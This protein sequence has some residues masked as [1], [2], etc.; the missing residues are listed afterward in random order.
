MYTPESLALIER[1]LRAMSSV[2]SVGAVRDKFESSRTVVEAV[3][4]Y[5]D[6]GGLTEHVAGGRRFVGPDP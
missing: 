4:A 3:L 5:F 1:E 6:E 2:L